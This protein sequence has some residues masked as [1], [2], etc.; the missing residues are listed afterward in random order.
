M[1]SRL[2]HE[3]KGVASSAIKCI[4]SS[5]ALDVVGVG[6]GDGCA[7][8][9]SKHRRAHT[10]CLSSSGLQLKCWLAPPGQQPDD[11]VGLLPSIA[12]GLVTLIVVRC[13][14]TKCSGSKLETHECNAP[15]DSAEERHC[16]GEPHRDCGTCRRALLH[17]LATDE[18][19]MVFPNASGAGAGS[20]SSTPGAAPQTPGGGACTAIA[21]RTGVP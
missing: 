3:F 10:N 14:S 5:P 7:L 8:R 2:L 12:P 1:T 13:V 17:N 20:D 19:L 9:T 4:V 15:G 11:I 21:F 18:T 6:D 16:P